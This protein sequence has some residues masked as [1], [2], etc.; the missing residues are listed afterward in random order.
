ME[1]N[2]DTFRLPNILKTPLQLPKKRWPD[3]MFREYNQNVDTRQ[4][5][6]NHF[7][8]PAYLNA[9][10]TVHLFQT[11]QSN[12]I[13]TSDMLSSLA[14]QEIWD[15]NTITGLLVSISYDNP[16]KRW[17]LSFRLLMTMSMS[18]FI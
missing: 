17:S 13:K 2:Q 12:V 4:T 9:Y 10:K 3:F 6:V 14:K 7:D 8:Y 11:S 5:I 1:S 18:S 15:K 16:P